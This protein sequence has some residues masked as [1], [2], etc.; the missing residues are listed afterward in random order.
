MW[1]M[2]EKIANSWFSFADKE[3]SNQNGYI[4]CDDL[5]WGDIRLDRCMHPEFGT[6]I[7]WGADLPME[8]T[9]DSNDEGHR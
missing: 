7:Q 3:I 5:S 6:G 9:G 8:V 4:S 1:S 2:V